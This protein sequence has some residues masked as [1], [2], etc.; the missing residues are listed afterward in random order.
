MSST[1]EI[2]VFTHINPHKTQRPKYFGNLIEQ[3]FY[4]TQLVKT[5]EYQIDN[6]QDILQQQLITLRYSNVLSIIEDTG[7]KQP[8]ARITHS[9][10]THAE[11]DQYPIL[12]PV[13][14]ALSVGGFFYHPKFK[15]AGEVENEIQDILSP[16]KAESA[17]ITVQGAVIPLE[18]A[19]M[20]E[21]SGI[22]RLR[23]NGDLYIARF[24]D[25][26]PESE[27]FDFTW[28]EKQRSLGFPF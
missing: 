13:E 23:G 18:D 22:I 20:H 27:Q 3:G 14:Y 25:G 15:N 1:Y 21:K 7:K 10:G 6:L 11:M 17:I 2:R 4:H 5:P 12:E 26:T 9:G 16:Y 28:P 19:A 24:S 8:V